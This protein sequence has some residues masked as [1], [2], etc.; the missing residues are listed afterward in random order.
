MQINNIERVDVIIKCQVYASKRGQIVNTGSNVISLNA[1]PNRLNLSGFLMLSS[2]IFRLQDTLPQDRYNISIQVLLYPSY[3]LSFSMNDNIIVDR[4]AEINKKQLNFQST[5]IYTEGNFDQF[6]SSQRL[7]YNN[8]IRGGISTKVDLMGLPFRLSAG[9]LYQF[10][11]H[12]FMLDKAAVEF[13]YLKYVEK[14]KQQALSYVDSSNINELRGRYDSIVGLDK[15][16]DWDQY[17][18]KSVMESYQTYSNTIDELKKTEYAKY[19]DTYEKYKEDLSHEAVENFN[20]YVSITDIDHK[21]YQ[22]DTSALIEKYG[23][24]YISEIDKIQ[25]LLKEENLISFLKK[26]N[27]KQQ[28]ADFKKTHQRYQSAADEMT[29]Y[30]EKYTFI[31]DGTVKKYQS[32][33]DK[34]D[35]KK[36]LRNTDDVSFIRK[37]TQASHGFD[38]ADFKEI[39]LGFFYPDQENTNYSISTPLLGYSVVYNKS[40]WILSSYFGSSKVLN[41]GINKFYRE[42]FKNRGAY[43]GEIGVGVGDIDKKSLI[44]NYSVINAEDTIDGSR[45]NLHLL[46]AKAKFNSTDNFCSIGVTYDYRI[47][48]RHHD[49]IKNSSFSLNNHFRLKRVLLNQIVLYKGSDIFLPALFLY[50]DFRVFR[51]DH[52]LTGNLGKKVPSYSL[53]HHYESFQRDTVSFTGN[54]ILA[55]LVFNL[56]ANTGLLINGSIGYSIHGRE[57][58]NDRTLNYSL[59][60]S[61]TKKI[62]LKNNVLD[63]RANSAVQQSW[64]YDYS[65]EYTGPVM[66]DY[67]LFKR[68]YSYLLNMSG[69]ISFDKIRY[70]QSLLYNKSD[71]DQHRFNDIYCSTD[72][73]TNIRNQELMLT[74]NVG[75]SI[76]DEFLY[77]FR[78]SVLINVIKNIKISAMLEYGKQRFFWPEIHYENGFTGNVSLH[79][80]L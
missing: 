49:I 54:N 30:K 36:M 79:I 25:K 80:T 72:I 61:I 17:E 75:Y 77:S 12:S 10:D 13:D 68:N 44:M 40:P 65:R 58:M 14:M 63:I 6:S 8:Y 3:Q 70:T 78:T 37:F 62:Q 59:S 39:K 2:N 74:S 27:N 56:S 60:A 41:S 53:Q 66:L 16:T 5:D 21:I 4:D 7:F 11:D 20:K 34:D 76:G 35:L 42:V 43:Q 67:Q 22:I 48:S 33:R 1:G 50:K 64:I 24:K 73:S 47:S 26:Y 52:I 51:S 71:I 23:D 28:L 45:K 32:L 18:V 15:I 9:T 29:K 38:F 69:Q 55:S 57:N 19:F 31:K 46:G